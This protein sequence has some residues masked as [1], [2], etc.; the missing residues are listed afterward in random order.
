MIHFLRIRFLVFEHSARTETATDGRDKW[1]M[2]NNSRLLRLPPAWN[3]IDLWRYRTTDI[4]TRPDFRFISDG[5]TKGRPKS[6]EDIT[7]RSIRCLI[8]VETWTCTPSVIDNASAIADG[9][10]DH[11]TCYS[12]W[13]SLIGYHVFVLMSVQVLLNRDRQTDDKKN[14]PISTLLLKYCKMKANLRHTLAIFEQ[15][16]FNNVK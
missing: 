13:L 10:D 4:F 7:Y 6:F 15:S 8:C 11:E 3:T 9:S 5:L 14:V 2:F 16:L 12:F 1:W